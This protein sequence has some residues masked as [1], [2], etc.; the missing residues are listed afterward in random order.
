MEEQISFGMW[1]RKQ[2]RGLDLTRQA[3]ANQIGCA[4]VT[5]RRI[6]A[7]TLKPSMELA[8]ILLEK[9]GIAQTELPQWISFARGFSGFPSQSVS[10]SK[11][12]ITN[13]PAP[14]TTFIGREK[15]QADVIK[16]I[17]KHR[18][19][20]LT[21]AGGIGKTRLSLQVGKI[22]L[23][24]Y[25]DGVWFVAFDS[26]SDA[27]LVPPT[28]AAVFDIREG[29]DRPVLE[30]LI[31]IIREKTAL[32][33][34][35]NC[36]HLLDACAQLITTLLT[37]CPNLKILATSREAL[38][39]E[40][41]ATY[42]TPSLDIPERK[43]I[44]SINHL[45]QYEAVTLFIERAALIMPYFCLTYDKAAPIVDICRTL[46]G[47]PLAIEL[48][49]ARVDVL[50]VNEI[51]EQLKHCLDLLINN[52]RI[53]Q[54]KHQTMRASLDWS[55]GLLTEK[56]QVFLR[57]LS[58]FAGGWT[59]ES[60]QAICDGDT[61]SLTIAL[62]KKSLIVVDQEAGRETRY[63][64]HEIVR[65]YA[66]KKLVE[67]GEEEST[68]T[69]HLKYYLQ[70]SEQAQLALKG[71]AQIK[72]YEL[73]NDEHDNIRTSLEWADKTDVE[74]GLYISGW[75]ARF[76]EDFDLRE[77]ERWLSKF[78]EKPE[79]YTYPR[80]RA[81]ALYAYGIILYLTMQNSLLGKTAEDCLALY[82]ASGDQRGE[83][84]GL[85]LLGRFMWAT[86]NIVRATELYQQ[87]LDL[88]E[89][90]GDMWRKAFVLGHLG[91]MPK[92]YPQRFFYWEAAINLLR[93]I[94][95]LRLLELYLGTLGN[96]EVL[97]GDL[98]L[99]QRHLEEAIQL[100][101]VLKQRVGKGYIL[102]ALSRIETIKGNFEKARSLLED[103]IAIAIELGDRMSY[104][105]DRA[106]L[107]HVIVQQGKI[108]EAH[109]IFLE[110]TQEFFKNKS[111]DGVVF[112]LEGMA[113]LDMAIDKPFIAAQ[114]IGWTDATRE[115]IGDTRPPIEQADV[116][117]IIVA[118]LEKIGEV[119]FSD[120][121]DEGQKMTLDEAV[122]LAFE[123]TNELK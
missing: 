75:L 123:H 33:I 115:K 110:T 8:G 41:E 93:K 21:G 78:L 14:L 83:I 119:A 43:N 36:E 2:R 66:R 32:L 87:A 27:G 15:E 5:L 63:R 64:F 44:D 108:F 51:L 84:D 59:L 82:R 112:A 48:A 6:E 22:F 104:L 30:I 95:D 73:L 107:G 60:A 58:V 7:G 28:V 65:Q 106:H 50:Q 113:C 39:V 68:C 57:Q 55:W 42:I 9:L 23:R 98:G 101:Q 92:D 118:C 80:A 20:S 35:D 71:F 29:T 47:I 18:L 24:D 99:A 97:N 67:A 16:L 4:E 40:G 122:T 114:L 12:P 86:Q 100:N 90:L 89:S 62:V 88:S 120:A 77:G 56:E 85:I 61:L 46:D 3:L 70:F 103:T 91:W 74:A 111:E 102:N 25:P 19:V 76:W 94:G 52:H 109:D 34:F 1:L 31:S 45:T 116:D 69:Q 96:Y 54:P 79:S 81:K 49:A 72:W 11:K 10:S 38:G 37:N 121:Y 26:L 105:W 117:K 17:T 13:L 53:V